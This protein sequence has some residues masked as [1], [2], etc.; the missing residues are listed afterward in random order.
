MQNLEKRVAAL[1]KATPVD[2]G[3]IFIHLVGMETKDAEI[4]R[5]EK[6]NKVWE[7]QSDESEAGLKERAKSEV[8]PPL[9]GCSTVF[10]CH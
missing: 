9:P 1:E 3:T 4:Q 7:R 2:V 10:L 8:T 5:I 6:G